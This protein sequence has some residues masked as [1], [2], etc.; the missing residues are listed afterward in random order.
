MSMSN[1][2]SIYFQDDVDVTA[3]AVP[4]LIKLLSDPDTSTSRQAANTLYQESFNLLPLSFVCTQLCSADY[5]F[6]LFYNWKKLS[7]KEAP[8]HALVESQDL[9][10][11]IVK[12]LTTNEDP[13][14]VKALAG[15]L[16]AISGSPKGLLSIFK[17]GGIPALIKMLSSPI[18]KAKVK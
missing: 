4:E 10:P 6:K 2:L 15:T 12:V 7:R 18:D 3:I 11:A 5:Y 9:I 14:T 17:S 16:T 13:E 1:F 8:R